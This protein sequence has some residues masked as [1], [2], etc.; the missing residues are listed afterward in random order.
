[1]SHTYTAQRRSRRSPEGALGVRQLHS[2]ADRQSCT[3]AVNVKCFTPEIVNDG[4][5]FAA[6][7]DMLALK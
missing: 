3:A 4:L 5:L 7:V 6:Y 1:M 2:P